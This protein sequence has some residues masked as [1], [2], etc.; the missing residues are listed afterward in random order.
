MWSYA[1][2][3]SMNYWYPRLVRSEVPTP[4]TLMVSAPCIIWDVEGPR[5]NLRLFAQQIDHAV[6]MLG[7]YPVFLRAGGTSNK[8]EWKDSCYLDPPRHDWD[9]QL[10]AII[11][12]AVNIAYFGACCGGPDL[13]LQTF[14]VRKL[15]PTKPIFHAF[16][17]DVPITR[18]YR[19]FVEFVKP[20]DDE[21]VD[22]NDV[23][24]P[25]NNLEKT[26]RIIKP[27]TFPEPRIEHVQAYWPAMAFERGEGRDDYAH[28]PDWRVKLAE[29]NA[30]TREE[31]DAICDLALR[32]SQP[33]AVV[34]TSWSIDILQDTDGKWWVTDMALA[35]SSHRHE[36]CPEWLATQAVAAS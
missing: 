21:S 27:F 8:H 3:N 16:G 30:I 17:G 19:V 10:N 23:S 12:H 34:E 13:D 24:S 5:P 29:M 36:A 22:E 26:K 1:H 14:A 25:E 6:E 7:G 20:K 31:L 15:I 32:A 9:A 2:P 28:D 33:F 35:S 4:D 18:E 11:D